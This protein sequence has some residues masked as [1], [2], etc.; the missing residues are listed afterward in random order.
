MVYYE[1]K[2]IKDVLIVNTIGLALLMDLKLVSQFVLQM[3][4]KVSS[5]IYFN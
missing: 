3:I 2:L 1:I 4:N 5:L